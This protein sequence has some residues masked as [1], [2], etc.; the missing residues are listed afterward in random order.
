MAKVMTYIA[1]WQRGRDSLIVP[2]LGRLEQFDLEQEKLPQYVERL[3]Q[4]FEGNDITEEDKAA[5]HR[6]T[7]HSVIGPALYKLM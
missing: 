2:L 4:T 3:E 6:A 1:L 5:K 7:F